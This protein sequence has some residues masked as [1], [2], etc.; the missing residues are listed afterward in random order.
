MD[1]TLFV[2]RFD[3]GKLLDRIRDESGFGR[4]GR[5]NPFCRHYYEVYTSPS[6]P[7]SWMIAEILPAGTWSM[8]FKN[9]RD[10]QDRKAISDLYGIHQTLMA[11]WMEA[12]TDL[13]NQCAHHGR[14]W[15]RVFT[16]KP[17]IPKSRELARHFRQNDRF[18]AHA[19][20]LNMFL[21]VISNGSTWQQ[22]LARLVNTSTHMTV[23]TMGFFV[24]WE[25]DPFWGVS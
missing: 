15:N 19:A 14:I 12:F 21:K 8:I 1:P 11:S 13:R 2:D 20:V 23:E 6:L 3:H 22:R 24:G 25:Q 4:P 9:I 5:Q 10:R 18:Y 16:K 7:P 17:M